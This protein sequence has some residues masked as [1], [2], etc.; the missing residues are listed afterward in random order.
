[1]A[2]EDRITGGLRRLADLHLAHAEARPD[3]LALVEGENRLTYG[4]LEQAVAETASWF[5]E[6]G[7][8]AGDRIF[9]VCENVIA[10]PVLMLAASRVDAWMTP[11]NAR[12]SIREIEQIR[13]HAGARRIFFTLESDAAAA[14]AGAFD[15]VAHQRDS[16]GPVAV[17]PEGTGPGTEAEPAFDDPAEQVACLLYTSGTTGAP[18]G[19]MLTHRGLIFMARIWADLRQATEADNSY[20]I[21]PVSHVYGLVNGVLG[22]LGCGAVVELEPRYTPAALYK[23]LTGETTIFQGVP[24]M[25]ARL[26]EYIDAE[27]L[28]FDPK[29][30][31]YASG[32][33]APVDLDLKRRI[34]KVFGMPFLIGYGLTEAAPTVSVV[35]VD[36]ARDDASTGPPVHETDIRLVDLDSGQDVGGPGREEETGELWVRGP[37]VM[38]GYYRNPDATAEALTDD[39]WLRTGDLARVDEN[40]SVWI[41]GRA[42]DVIIRSGFNVHP[43]EVEAEL[44]T[45]PDVTLCGVVGRAVSSNEEVIAFVQLAPGSSATEDDLQAHVRETLAGYK[46]PS[47]IVIL[48]NLPATLSGKV[49]HHELR[50]LAADL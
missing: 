24:A 4:A 41:V 21:L 38:K 47:R 46:R 31:R 25:Y 29:Q 45:H 7:V 8:G 18:K 30:L 13:D 27:N 32:G 17:G 22:G 39:G 36:G 34:E 28:P 6:L 50:S 33:G 26:L 1:M 5:R 12:L 9:V 2:S 3:A 19:V 44:L 23:A 11:L 42:K 16:I 10:A 43:T 48:E 40:G 49:R 35:R 20:A 15:G 14:H 37:Q